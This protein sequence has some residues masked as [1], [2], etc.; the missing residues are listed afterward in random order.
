MKVY[1][2]NYIIVAVIMS[3]VFSVMF[4]IADIC[5]TIGYNIFWATI[6][7]FAVVFSH[8]CDKYVNSKKRNRYGKV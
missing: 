6:L 5:T 8:Y 1:L 2:K 4:S 7:A 3:I